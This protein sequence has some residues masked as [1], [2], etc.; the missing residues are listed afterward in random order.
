MS[1]TGSVNGHF[2][3]EPPLKWAEIKDSRFYL[4]DKD[5][6]FETAVVLAVDRDD[7]ETDDGVSIIFTS[8]AAVPWRE[9]F[10][11]R[12]LE[13]DTK[14]LAKDL[15]ETGRTLRGVMTVSGDWATDVW[16]VVADGDGVRKEEARF[17]WPDGSE[18]SL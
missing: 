7:K 16:R 14:A 5:M 12:G 13:R 11:C 6:S 10:D 1:Y 18:V 17:T 2:Q 9:S 4:E 3:I 15:A 8:S